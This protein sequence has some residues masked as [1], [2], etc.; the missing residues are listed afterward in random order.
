MRG[1]H[2]GQKDS[3]IPPPGQDHH[4]RQFK[5]SRDSDASFA[6][7]RPSSVGVG[8]PS[9]ALVDAYKDRSHQAETLRAINSYLSSQSSSI[10]LPTGQAPSSKQIKETVAFLLLQLDYPVEL[11]SVEDDLLS[12]LKFFKCPIKINGSTLRA[13]NTPHNFPSFL[14]LMH[15]LVH[16]ANCSEHL[17]KKSGSSL[18]NDEILAHAFDT[19]LK[20][21]ADDQDSEEALD[22][23]FTAKLEKDKD[24]VKEGIAWLENEC[25]E[26]AA[27]VER[28]KTAPSERV[29]LETEKG[30]LEQD[31]SKFHVMLGEFKQRI[32]STE[33]VL[34]EKRAAIVAKVEETNRCIAENEELKK[35]VESQ[36]FNIR[37]AERMRR[38]LQAVEREFEEAEA[39]RN[40]LEEKI[41]DL[42]ATIGKKFKELEAV[43]MDCNQEARRLKLENIFQHG[44]NA[45]GS[46]PAEVMGIDYKSTLKPRLNSLADDLKKSCLLKLEE[47]MSLQQQS[48]ELANKLDIKRQ[49]LSQLQSQIDEMEAQLNH[50]KTEIE[51]YQS[52]CALEAKSMV[53]SIGNEAHTL[54]LLEKEAAAILQDKKVKLGEA[55][56][57]SE[58]QVQMKARQL[59]TLVDSVSKYKEHTDSCIS[60][61]NNKLT[62]TEAAIS[63]A[64]NT[65]LPLQLRTNSTA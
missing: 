33:K 64:N 18:K 51:D 19:Y 60:R 45:N 16:I 36:S 22:A 1:Y 6:S 14:A 35:Q 17:R 23:E 65:V 46:T 12:V 52:R 29:R 15:W 57:Q 34:Q 47:D 62:E 32:E 8:R 31:V 37:D 58:E 11:K 63:D 13:P 41:W 25:G 49:D 48:S 40:E 39:S 42:E 4:R 10:V 20:Y 2:R 21:I 56:K 50:I 24:E 27:E 59:F 26:L 5:A 38:E 54:M 55:I 44:L 3:F 28:L 43:A 53:E 30:C 7:S 61:M 9:A